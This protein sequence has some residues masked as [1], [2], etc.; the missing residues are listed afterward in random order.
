MHE[1]IDPRSVL[2][3]CAGAVVTLGAVALTHVRVDRAM[4]GSTDRISVIEARDE[5][6]RVPLPGTGALAIV[7][8]G[9]EGRL[10]ELTPA[11]WHLEW[12]SLTDTHRWHVR[13]VPASIAAD[14]SGSPCRTRVTSA[15]GEIA[16][17]I[18]TDPL[19]RLTVYREWPA[20]TLAPPPAHELIG[21]R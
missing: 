1:Q 6:I 15:H 11:R 4:P 18:D 17:T 3:A 2:A 20:F 8:P 5:A 13:I 12:T 21:R 19:T 14:P 16:S 9:A 10:V 7:P